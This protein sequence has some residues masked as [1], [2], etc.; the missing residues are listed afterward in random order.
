MLPFLVLDSLTYLV[1]LAFLPVLL[2]QALGARRRVLFLPEPPGPRSGKL[3]SGEPFRLLVLGDS[4]GASVGSPTQDQGLI[5]QLRRRFATDYE[6]SWTVWAKTGYTT[7][8]TLANLTEREDEDFD[9]VVVSLGVNDVTGLLPL[10]TWLEKQAQ[11]VET[12]RRRFGARHISLA[13]LPPVG[14]FPLLPQP[15]RFCLGLRAKLYTRAL[16]WKFGGQ[17]DLSVMELNEPF[18]REVMSMDGFHPGPPVYELWAQN[19][20]RDYFGETV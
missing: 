6:V 7:A 5:G 11:L 1:T 19:V 9:L 16:K 13:G 10:K 20:V 15:L 3:G 17:R 2:F 4:A 8:D 12:L 18:D 14:R